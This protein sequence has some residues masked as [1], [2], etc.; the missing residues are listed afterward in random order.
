MRRPSIHQLEVFCKVVRLESMARAAEELCV[1]PSSVSM[2]IQELER[3]F[4]VPLLV[5]GP[6]RTVP[7]SA[8]KALYLRAMKVLEN[9]DAVERDLAKLGALESGMLRFASSRTIGSALVRPVLQVFERTYP[10]VDVAY[11]VMANSQQANAEV[12]DERAEFA[13]VG[14]VRADGV[15]GVTPLFEESLIVVLSRGHPLAA[16]EP[17]TMA[18]LGRQPLLLRESPVL[19]RD[20]V[21]A[22]LEGAGVFP[23]VVELGS[24]EAIKAEVVAGR[25]VAV[26][27]R[28]TVEEE[29]VEGALVARAVVGFV[30]SR[31]VYLAT[32]SHTP[33]SPPADSFVAL[34]RQRYGAVA[35]SARP[36]LERT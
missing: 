35:D 12:L 5:R 19:G 27:P 1:A 17:L 26:L 22:S 23:D 33:L 28:T 20:R 13:L 6:R 11:H 8:G 34:L 24:T 16:V 18:D 36:E 9:L 29:L 32:L 10:K 2:Q 21:V 4:R 15:L 30:P 7:T 14:R 25:G 31:T 3:R